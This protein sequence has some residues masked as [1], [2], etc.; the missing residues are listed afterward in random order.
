[1]K[2]PEQ[3]KGVICNILERP[4]R[5]SMML[6]SVI[7]FLMDNIGNQISTKKISDHYPKII[8]TLDQDPVADYEGIR[9]INALDYFVQKIEI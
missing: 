5:S 4:H 2:S 7:R 9:R 6:E 8:M 1:M 3:L